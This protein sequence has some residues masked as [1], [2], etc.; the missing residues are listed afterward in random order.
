MRQC[1]LRATTIESSNEVVLDKTHYIDE[2]I[3]RDIESSLLNAI[4]S[5]S[6]STSAYYCDELQKHGFSSNIVSK[7]WMLGHMNYKEKGFYADVP[8]TSYFERNPTQSESRS[9]L[10]DTDNTEVTSSCEWRD[11]IESMIKIDPLEIKVI[12]FA[13][14]G[15]FPEGSPMRTKYMQR[16]EPRKIAYKLV[17]ISETIAKELLVDLKTVDNEHEEATR[18]CRTLLAEGKEVADKSRKPV[19]LNFEDNDENGTPFREKN[20]G[21]IGFL[22]TK[23]ALNLVKLDYQRSGPNGSTLELEKLQQHIDASFQPLCSD[24]VRRAKQEIM[25]TRQMLESLILE[26]LKGI[27]T[28]ASSSQATVNV[29]VIA[30]AL[31]QK[32]KFVASLVRRI[33]QSED[34]YLRLQYKKITDFGGFTKLDLG[35]RPKYELIDL[36]EELKGAEL[37]EKVLKK[38]PIE[39]LSYSIA[40]ITTS[41]AASKVSEKLSSPND[42]TTGSRTDQV[43]YSNTDDMMIIPMP[44]CDDYANVMFI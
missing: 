10:F 17:Q 12:T 8:T 13:S 31:V 1:K 43:D 2:S 35:K 27:V 11:Y 23:I 37:K 38:T 28:P 19:R 7:D 15:M 32:R 14:K 40:S 3:F 44:G 6:I 30:E 4:G 24:P 18:Y 42:A 5:M 26:G 39:R 41:D 16:I 36:T 21:Q 25:I 20:W 9:T 22:I 34:Q 33:L 29:Q